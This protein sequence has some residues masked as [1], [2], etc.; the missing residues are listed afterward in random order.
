MEETQIEWNQQHEQVLWIL[1]R[2]PGIWKAAPHDLDGIFTYWEE[3][4]G[5]EYQEVGYDLL[6]GLIRQHG[7]DPQHVWADL[8][9]Q[10]QQCAWWQY[11]A[12]YE[13]PAPHEVPS[14]HPRARDRGKPQ[15]GG[16]TAK[17]PASRTKT[18][19]KI[20][21]KGW[22]DDTIILNEVPRAHFEQ[23]V[24]TKVRT[25]VSGLPIRGVGV[26][27]ASSSDSAVLTLS[28]YDDAKVA[29]QLRELLAGAPPRIDYVVF[30]GRLLLQSDVN[31]WNTLGHWGPANGVC[32]KRTISVV[33]NLIRSEH[34]EEFA[35]AL[36]TIVSDDADWI[37]DEYV[38][39]GPSH[40]AGA[41]SEARGRKPEPSDTMLPVY[42]E[43]TLIGKV[44]LHTVQRDYGATKDGAFKTE[45]GLIKGEYSQKGSG[46]VEVKFLKTNDLFTA[47]L[48]EY[49]STAKKRDAPQ[50]TTYY[51]IGPGVFVM[52][53]PSGRQY[54]WETVHAWAEAASIT[55]YTLTVDN[56]GVITTDGELSV[57]MEYVETLGLKGIRFGVG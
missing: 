44:S 49:V 36:G 40:D 57:L 54:L 8:F 27:K 42:F 29:R 2:M 46:S 20:T 18:S 47:S 22:S 32:E 50:T 55:P 11:A 5:G 31:L 16:S 28:P 30:G 19:L 14:A 21:V 35:K 15:K 26:V 7:G 51:R 25:G 1:N 9:E 34:Y 45:H 43:K 38:L 4:G 37:L 3:Y 24:N 39:A 48:R 6:R 23:C 56:H 17:K 13:E 33:G 10:V 41:D 12:P 53:R 52:R